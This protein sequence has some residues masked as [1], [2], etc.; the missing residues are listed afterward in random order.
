MPFLAPITGLFQA[1]LDLWG[2]IKLR[3]LEIENEKMRN[4]HDLAMVKAE[5]DATIAEYNAKIRVVE[6]TTK[7]Q[8][9][10]TKANTKKEI[11]VT[12]IKTD[13]EI[14]KEAQK[15][16]GANLVDSKYALGRLYA[17][18]G[19][20]RYITIPCAITITILF[21]MIDALKSATQ[22]AIT[23]YMAALA[24]IVTYQAYEIAVK[25]GTIM[26]AATAFGVYASAVDLI[27]FCFVHIVF[28]QFGIRGN[29]STVKKLMKR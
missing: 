9:E 4:E 10:V 16:L 7:G 23:I 29:N 11:K 21:S 13:A 12:Q 1:G 5:T 15:R 24:T 28:A 27:L 8:I 3:N 22:P 14:A 6:S 17:Q 26:D 18:E 19:W 20:A 2:K 25:Y